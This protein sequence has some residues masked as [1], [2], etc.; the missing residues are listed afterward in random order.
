MKKARHI[1]RAR[2]LFPILLF[3]LAVLAVIEPTV[4]ASRQNLS[5]GEAL[6][7]AERPQSKTQPVETEQVAPQEMSQPANKDKEQATQAQ[8]DT[9]ACGT[10]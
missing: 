8:L 7:Q 6:A 4:S 9:T 10:Y 2:W 1:L 5:I 3:G